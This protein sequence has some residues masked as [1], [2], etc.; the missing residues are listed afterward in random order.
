MVEDLD[1]S[2]RFQVAHLNRVQGIQNIKTE[3]PMQL[4]KYTTA[5]PV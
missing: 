2:R 4:I 3:I 1:A 5:V